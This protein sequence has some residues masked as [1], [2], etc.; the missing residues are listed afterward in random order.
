LSRHF[1]EARDLLLL[2]IDLR[3]LGAAVRWEAAR[4]GALFPHVY[5]VIPLSTVLCATS[6]PES[7]PERAQFAHDLAARA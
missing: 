7:A 5:G 2:T 3:P 1:A 6:I 4:G